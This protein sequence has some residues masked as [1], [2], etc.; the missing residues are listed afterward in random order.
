MTLPVLL[1]TGFLG[2]GKTTAINGL[3]QAGHGQRVAAIVND[4]G[5]IN[6]DAELLTG[7][8]D[9][10]IGL[11]NG[12]ICCTL[13]GDLLRTLRLVLAQVP[14]PERIVIEASGAADPRGIIEMVMDPV[15]WG[16]VSLDAV[17]CLVDAEDCADTPGRMRDPL[18]LAQLRH[19][20]FVL[21]SKT[22]D[23]PPERLAAV[24]AALAMERKPVFDIDTGPLPLAALL[25]D[26]APPRAAPAPGR[27]IADR[28]VTVEW[29]HPGPVT[30]ARFQGALGQVSPGLLRAKGLLWLT[31]RTGRPH[32][33]QLVG[34]RATFAPAPSD[35]APGCRLVLI[36]ERGQFDPEAARAALDRLADAG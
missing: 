6:I 36:G 32:L 34:R 7:A 19:S 25:G 11:K 17:V 21:L 5:A 4:F 33:F 12:C 28:F 35:A 27:V 9:Q 30:L 22:R 16:T 14:R 20:D 26:T 24:S 1:V 29:Q 31:D 18:W 15:L 2:A 13:Q 23:L 8:A 10:V 3:L